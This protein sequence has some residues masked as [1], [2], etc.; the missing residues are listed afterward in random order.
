[1]ILGT[2]NSSVDFGALDRLFHMELG[3]KRGTVSGLKNAIIVA[4]AVLF[5]VTLYFPDA[6]LP[7]LLFLLL[8]LRDAFWPHGKT[9][10]SPLITH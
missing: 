1:M 2:S 5:G 4:G 7:I 6:V 8:I 3:W 10:H 9:P